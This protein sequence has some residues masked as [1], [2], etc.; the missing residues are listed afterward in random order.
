MHQLCS[1]ASCKRVDGMR[2]NAPFCG[3]L[4]AMHVGCALVLKHSCGPRAHAYF[5]KPF[6]RAVHGGAQVRLGPNGVEEVLGL[7]PLSPL[8]EKGVAEL[9]PVLQ[10][11]IETGVA[12]AQAP[13]KE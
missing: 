7:G 9:K 8:E 2:A 11:N 5:S 10:K 12:F 13:P 4:P 6:A 1:T 3:C